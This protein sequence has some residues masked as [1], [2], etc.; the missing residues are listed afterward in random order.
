MNI[1]GVTLAR[2][3]SKGIK[4]KNIIKL[5]NLPLIAHTIIEAKKCKFFTD[6]IVSTDSKKISIIAKSFGASV[7]FLR[8]KILSS[9]KSIF[10][11]IFT[12]GL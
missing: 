2:G 11:R 1:L 4:N 9:S 7:P 8:P 3:G 6:Y 12:Y 5:N 10:D